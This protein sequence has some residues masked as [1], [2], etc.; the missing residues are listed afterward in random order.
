M[1]AKSIQDLKTI[2]Q[3][4]Q[5]GREDSS[6][7]PGPQGEASLVSQATL[8]QNIRD[9]LQQYL[10]NH[11]I[12][13]PVIQK[14]QADDQ[15]Q[16]DQVIHYKNEGDEDAQIDI[17][18]LYKAESMLHTHCDSPLAKIIYSYMQKN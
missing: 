9:Q 7:V 12:K 16:A 13:Q 6:H 5:Q 11:L 8:S 2:N 4:I 3:N 17:K 18:D 14:L 1:H 10:D 15:V